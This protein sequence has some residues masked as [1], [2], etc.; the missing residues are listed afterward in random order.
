MQLNSTKYSRILLIFYTFSLSVCLAT[1]PS[2]S[3]QYRAE[4]WHDYRYRPRKGHGYYDKP[5]LGVEGGGVRQDK[6]SW[7]NREMLL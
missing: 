2:H 5:R 4:K 7:V 1:M 3:Y 6:S